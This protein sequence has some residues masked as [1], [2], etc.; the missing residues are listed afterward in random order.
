MGFDGTVGLLD[1][2]ADGAVVPS[3]RDEV[4]ILRRFCRRDFVRSKFI[5]HG[6][7]TI[8]IPPS[9]LVSLAAWRSTF[10]LPF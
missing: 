5:T 6:F 8:S 9:R 4:E 7:L 3:G 10:S 1:W 2:V